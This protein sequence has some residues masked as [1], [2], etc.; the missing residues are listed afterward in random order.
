M[1][2]DQG[3]QA[4]VVLFVEGATIIADSVEQG[5]GGFFDL[6]GDRYVADAHL[7]HTVVHIGY[8][9]LGDGLGEGRSGISF[10]RKPA[11]QQNDM[12]YDHL[13][14]ALRCVRHAVD[15]IERWRAGLRH[16]EAIKVCCRAVVGFAAGQYVPQRAFGGHGTI[17]G[18]RC[19]L[20]QD[21]C[22]RIR[23]LGRQVGTCGFG[24]PFYSHTAVGARI[25]NSR[26]GAVCAEGV[27][28]R[29]AGCWLV[30]VGGSPESST[31]RCSAVARRWRQKG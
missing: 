24:V 22:G 2:R 10:L 26:S 29:I 17:Q 3:R 6:A 21:V 8:E 16:E 9:G 4:F 14:P 20:M 18:L 13:E 25:A 15:G 31:C 27:Q 1:R 30:G 5:G 19:S 12:E 28:H 23:R 7:A 11:Q